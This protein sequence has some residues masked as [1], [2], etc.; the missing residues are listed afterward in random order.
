MIPDISAMLFSLTIK[1]TL[2]LMVAYLITRFVSRLSSSERHLVWSL[3][4]AGVLL[5]PVLA[6]VV[7]KYQVP[8]AGFTGLIEFELPAMKES[9][10][11]NI[12]A[13]TTDGPAWY[14]PALVL[15]KGTDAGRVLS[16]AY[17][18]VAAVLLVYIGF[19]YL[20]ISHAVEMFAVVKNQSVLD[21]VNQVKGSLGLKRDIQVYENPADT[22]PWVW[23]IMQP[24]IILP[25]GFS[26]WT[27]QGQRNALI[28]ELSH[29]QRLDLLSFI[30]AR[31]CCCLYWFHPLAW[32]GYRKMLMEAE[33]TCDDRVLLKGTRASAYADQLMQLATSVFTSNEDRMLAPSMASSTS[34]THRVRNI[35][36]GGSRRALI[37]HTK[38]VMSGIVTFI[39]SITL[40]AFEAMA[41]KVEP[42]AGDKLET[43]AGYD[44]Q[45]GASIP[46]KTKIDDAASQS[47]LM[48]PQLF[49]QIDEA[50]EF[51]QEERHVEAVS[52]LEELLE[53]KDLNDFETATL[54]QILANSYYAQEQ[55]AAAAEACEAGLKVRNVPEKLA[56]GLRLFLAQ[57]YLVQENY[58]AVV[59]ILS[60][61]PDT[62]FGTDLRHY[63]MKAQ[64]YYQLGRLHDTISQ[65]NAARDLLEVNGD[66]PHLHM[67]M[68]M[69][70]AYQGLDDE[71]NFN[72]I[73]DEARRLHP[74]AMQRYL[75]KT[76][77]DTG[78]DVTKGLVPIVQP[79]PVYPPRA[80]ARGL[81]GFAI[82]EF[83]VT[84]QG[85]TRDIRI[86]ETSHTGIFDRPTIEAAE[87]I[88]Y[89]PRMV[90]G[91]AVDVPG[92]RVKFEYKL[93]AKEKEV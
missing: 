78:A 48:R 51:Q 10:P 28:H 76:A 18:V 25:R 91:K 21:L 50:M 65:L 55:Y 14:M 20:R 31:C 66:V 19:V 34:L 49:A 80:R 54:N 7:P 57:I 75:L 53:H 81:E 59:E 6:L 11:V 38:I 82:V 29:I 47:P 62:Y 1:S 85:T 23:G 16:M 30:M 92:V 79:A 52:V 84:A 46:R 72:R 73:V 67:L 43:T 74:D 33:K 86:V 71:V 3:A 15:L 70:A 2:I 27:L 12:T 35:L 58:Q 93:A 8:I 39:F 32:V 60:G 9:L 83:T 44:Y 5:L 37:S 68:L 64:A 56:A 4:F 69:M 36:D 90:D 24:G 89:K 13:V 40:V 87:N 61:E 41:E 42:T 17:L 63:I 77:N 22:T 26:S 45:V 88:I